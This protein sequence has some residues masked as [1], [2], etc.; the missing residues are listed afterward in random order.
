MGRHRIDLG[1]ALDAEIAKRAARY[2][3][4]QTIYYAIGKVVSIATI[5]RRMRELRAGVCPACR[6]PLATSRGATP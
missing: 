6:R 1:P 3:S 4:A 5:H 2:E